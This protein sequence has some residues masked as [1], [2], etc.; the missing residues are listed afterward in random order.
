[1]TIEYCWLIM[2]KV[3]IFIGVNN[4]SFIWNESKTIEML[5]QQVI[6]TPESYSINLKTFRYSHWILRKARADCFC[7]SKSFTTH[8]YSPRSPITVDIIERLPSGST[9]DREANPSKFI[10]SSPSFHQVTCDCSGYFITHWNVT[11]SPS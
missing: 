9:C 5:I 8:S 11:C 10:I 6:L 4:F 3:N 7:P 2:C 1:M